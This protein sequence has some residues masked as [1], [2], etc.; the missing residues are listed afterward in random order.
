[1]SSPRSHEEP[2]VATAVDA[3][4]WP[5]TAHKR[6]P[7]DSR[8]YRQALW[9]IGAAVAEINPALVLTAAIAGSVYRYS[10]LWCVLLAVPIVLS[11]IA[12]S[13]RISTER[14]LGLVELL[15]RDYGSAVA[16][17]CAG[18]ILAVN[19]VLVVADLMAVTEGFSI[20]LQMPRMFFVAACAFAV[21]YVLIFRNYRRI[22]RLVAVL[23][24][25][26]L[27]Y[28][29]SVFLAHAGWSSV[30][31]HSFVPGI[32]PGSGYP[33]AFIAILGSLL[34]PHALGWQSRG[35]QAGQS[36]GTGKSQLRNAPFLSVGFCY[37]IIVCSGA[38]LHAVDPGALTM[39]MASQALAPA[40]GPG[41]ATVLFALAIIGAGMA[42]LPAMISAMSHS[43]S[44]AMGWRSGLHETP[45]EAKRFYVLISSTILVA[46]SIS[47]ARINPVSVLYWS[48]IVA[49]VLMLPVLGLILVVSNNRRSIRTANSWW[50]NFWIGAAGGSILCAALLALWWQFLG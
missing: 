46:G 27:I 30:V 31:Y 47:F 24:L 4:R 16:I 49:G 2:G 8:L 36:S 17:G 21:W 35:P 26:L 7:E 19:I 6:V 45:W 1:M 23:A 34:M 43:A 14:G 20:I 28:F 37:A 50:Q 48:Q 39:R 42:A 41:L 3:V 25:P 5:T 10:L 11:V 32:P 12:V 40:V 44:E 15:R 9:K 13:R 29:A 18:I 38:L 22:T 33:A